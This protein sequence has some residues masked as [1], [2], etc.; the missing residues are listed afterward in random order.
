MR[1]NLEFSPH[2]PQVQT[3]Y[4]GR[5]IA[6]WK[7][8][9]GPFV[10]VSVASCLLAVPA[11]P[12]TATS[13]YVGGNSGG[14]TA[15]PR[16]F[17]PPPPAA[18][19]AIAK[20]IVTDFRAKCDGV[21]NDNAAFTAFNTWGRV[22]KLPISLTIPSGSVCMFSS[23]TGSGNWFAKGIKNL[24]VLGYGATL[25]DKNGAGNGFFAGGLGIFGDNRHSSRV[26][27]VAAGAMRVTL[28]NPSES[29]RFQT[30]NWALMTGFDMMGYG[31]PPNP[32]FFEY[33]QITGVNSSTGIITFSA[34]LKNTYKSTWPLYNAGGAFQSDQGGPAT[35]YALDPSWDTQVE[36]RG[37]T[38][39]QAGQTYA[40]GRSI[41]YRDV[42]FTGNA[43]GIPTVNMVWQ[44]INTN[45]SSCYME[46]DK[47]VGTL[48]ISG[49]NIHKVVFQSASVNLFRMDGTSVTSS[50][51]GT[52][53]KSV[54]SNSTI[55]SFQPGAIAY[56]SS[57]ETTCTGCVLGEI[58]IGGFL[59]KNITT[60]FSMNNGILTV[61][62]SHG[63]VT[64]AIPGANLVWSGYYVEQGTFKVT[65]VTQDATNTYIRTSLTGGFPSQPG[66]ASNLGI[67]THPAPKFTCTNCTGSVDAI[68]LSQAPAGAPLWSYSKR[69]YTGNTQPALVPVWGTLVSAKF[70]VT[71]PYAGTSAL[72]FYLNAFVIE[73]NGTAQTTTTWTPTI[74]SKVTGPRTVLSG[75]VS[76]AQ[77]GDSLAVPGAIWLVNNQIYPTF[78][79]N[80]SGQ[81]PTVWP[82]VTLEIMT[83][84]GIQ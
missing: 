9:F 10:A 16:A 23:T 47:L 18:P 13:T 32:A 25:S 21:A 27:T 46:V 20:N 42:T 49:V 38:I 48:V 7:N 15:P 30:G 58:A 65:D 14:D 84:Q 81:T 62:K 51:N 75:S 19:T 34:P 66:G 29:R 37:L 71:V 78:N 36:Y 2:V 4:A 28:N 74:N 44:A 64:W 17:P 43:C 11:H 5:Q 39:S 31:Y 1:W 67:R 54:I 60:N 83:D 82:S 3:A 22:Q 79:V 59:E 35:L 24:L 50:M 6:S 77:I 61:P 55:A 12:Q 57:N 70:D 8:V 40:N 41:T 69:T 56:G 63:P 72:N 52:P 45:M 33:V 76:G 68:D 73:S 53:I 26:A 80:I